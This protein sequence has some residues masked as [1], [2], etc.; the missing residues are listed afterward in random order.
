MRDSRARLPLFGRGRGPE[1]AD[2]LAQNSHAFAF[3]ETAL[4]GP[5]WELLKGATAISQ[6]VLLGE[7]H[8]DKLTPIFAGALY[9]P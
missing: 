7:G 6:F 4:S 3:D 5:G 9:S 2:L 8:D 1:P